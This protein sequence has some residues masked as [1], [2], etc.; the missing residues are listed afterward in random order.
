MNRQKSKCKLSQA[1]K[2]NVHRDLDKASEERHIPFLHLDRST[3]KNVNNETSVPKYPTYEIHLT[4]IC[5]F[6]STYKKY[7]LFSALHGTF[8]KI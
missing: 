8:S 5:I 7:I 2:Q 1:N 6:H 3:Y 4:D